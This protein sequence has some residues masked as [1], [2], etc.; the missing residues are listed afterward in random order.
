M[1]TGTD[2][3]RVLVRE[4]KRPFLL[5]RLLEDAAAQRAPVL[6][7]EVLL[8]NFE[9]H[10]VLQWREIRRTPPDVI[11]AE[12]NKIPEITDLVNSQTTHKLKY[13]SIEPYFILTL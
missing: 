5:P 1:A 3:H 9:I 7:G 11:R 12:E 10:R 13:G 8:R 4:S 2:E 6:P